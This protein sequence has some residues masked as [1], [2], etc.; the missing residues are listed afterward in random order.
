MLSTLRNSLL[1][2][3]IDC[4]VGELGHLFN[5]QLAQEPWQGEHEAPLLFALRGLMFHCTVRCLFGEPFESYAETTAAVDEIV[6][7]FHAFDSWF[8]LASSNLPHVTLPAF[9][10]AKS[11]LIRMLDSFAQAYRHSEDTEPNVA[12]RMRGTLGEEGLQ[13]WLLALLWASEANT[14]PTLFW[15]IVHLLSSP[16]RLDLIRMGLEHMLQGRDIE[17]VTWKELQSCTD[18]RNAVQETI[19]LHSPPV[20]VRAARQ[21]VPVGNFVVPV[22]HFLCLSPYWAH[23][24]ESLYGEDASDWKP[25]RWSTRAPGKAHKYDFLSFGAGKYRCPGQNFAY[26]SLMLAAAKLLL[27]FNFK[28]A[29]GQDAPSVD[30]RNLVGI[31]KPNADL[32]VRICP[33]E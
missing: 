30:E 3:R 24:S 12:E 5:R 6:A 22:G 29:P 18:L 33:R 8:E 2:N 26:L 28:A 1:A 15:L 31:T 27:R 21:P 11:K 7:D 17:E 32:L 19:R 10:K 25:E 9:T 20:I 4:Y 16:A 14:I 13:N 23:R